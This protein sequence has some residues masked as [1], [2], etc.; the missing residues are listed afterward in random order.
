VD[1]DDYVG[2]IDRWHW[3]GT[4]QM[5]DGPDTAGGKLSD[6]MYFLTGRIDQAIIEDRSELDTALRGFDRRCDGQLRFSTHTMQCTDATWQVAL[7]ALLDRSHAIVMDLSGFSASHRG[8]AYEISR[9][10]ERVPL[11]RFILL[12]NDSTDLTLLQTVLDEAW[13]R[14]GQHSVNVGVEHPVIR[15]FKIGGNKER[16]EHESTVDWKRR[17]LNRID[18]ERLTGMLYDAAL[19]GRTAEEWADLNRPVYVEWG[20]AIA[21]RRVRV[22]AMAGLALYLA[23]TLVSS[24]A[25]LTAERAGPDEPPPTLSR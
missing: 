16:A 7:D 2:L 6:I 25:F 5:L 18:R 21:S 17:I 13:A 8:C 14:R 23:V 3:I 24:A 11:T 19:S 10:V 1:M 20:R 15:L 4:L 9:L 22:V 12:V